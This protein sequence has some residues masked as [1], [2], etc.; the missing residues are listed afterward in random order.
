MNPHHYSVMSDADGNWEYTVS[1]PDGHYSMS[2]RI[3]DNFWY[4]Y[5][6]S[7]TFH[8]NRFFTVKREYITLDVP[9]IYQVFTDNTFT[10]S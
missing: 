4:Q 3:G 9:V 10:L 8:I 2:A 5:P 7:N 6:I 1:L